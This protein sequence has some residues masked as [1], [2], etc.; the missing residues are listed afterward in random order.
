MGVGVLV[1][2][3]CGV[4]VIGMGS[5]VSGAGGVLTIGG[6]EIGVGV[7]ERVGVVVSVAVGV[8]DGLGV[9]V[10][11]GVVIEVCVGCVSGDGLEVDSGGVA[12]IES[13]WGV[14]AAGLALVLT[15]AAV[16]DTR[17]VNPEGMSFSSVGRAI[18]SGAM[19]V[20]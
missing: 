5:G 11:D 14:P 18:S 7:A 9:L 12:L 17:P 1:G 13:C 3:S 16:G 2:R 10:D 15:G 20:F 8:C 6:V 19:A 4:F